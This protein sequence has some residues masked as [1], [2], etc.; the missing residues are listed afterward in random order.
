[1]TLTITDVGANESSSGADTGRVDS[2]RPVDRIGF[3]VLHHD[4]ADFSL[5]HV[6]TVVRIFCETAASPKDRLFIQQNLKIARPI[7]VRAV[8]VELVSNAAFQLIAEQVLQ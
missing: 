2:G 4:A 3:K 8:A 1:M 6:D 5:G 7:I